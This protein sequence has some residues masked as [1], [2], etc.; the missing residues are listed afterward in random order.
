MRMIFLHLT[1]NER[2][3][4]K[5]MLTDEEKAVLR[6]LITGGDPEADLNW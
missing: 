6:Q 3:K 5:G 4:L 1:W 2:Q